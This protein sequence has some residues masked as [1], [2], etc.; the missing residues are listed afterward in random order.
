MLKVCNLSQLFHRVYN[1]P[2]IR[3]ERL[4]THLSLIGNANLPAQLSFPQIKN[5]SNTI[6]PEFNLPILQI[7]RRLIVLSTN[8]KDYDHVKQKRYQDD[9]RD[10]EILY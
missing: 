3:L 4:F 6:S 5:P 2:L 7:A 10:G 1:T 8:Q 9:C